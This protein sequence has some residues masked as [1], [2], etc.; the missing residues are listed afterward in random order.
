MRERLTDTQERRREKMRTRIQGERRLRRHGTRVHI[1]K[2]LKGILVTSSLHNTLLHQRVDRCLRREERID[3]TGVHL[4]LNR[5]FERWVDFTCLQFLPI[6]A[7]EECMRLD[8]GRSGGTR[9]ETLFGITCEQAFE[10]TLRW[11]RQIGRKPQLTVENLLVHDVDVLTVERRQTG[12]HLIDQRSQTPPVDRTAVSLTLEHL[13]GK[14]L[15][16]TAKGVCALITGD[17]LAETKV[18]DT[19]VATRIEENVLR[20]E[21]TIHDVERMQM[22]Q[23]KSDF[24]SVEPNAFLTEFAL[25]LEMEE[26][27]TT[28]HVVK[29]HVEFVLGL[30]GVVEVYNERMLNLL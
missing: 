30:E 17:F 24:G 21:V 18:G 4:A 20:L 6:D 2:V 14:V 25:L 5:R 27:F 13:G 23:S 28:V 11:F 16:R 10:E 22:R 12:E 29:N 1:S 7:S 3:L 26:E 9:A 8:I 19:D 15:G